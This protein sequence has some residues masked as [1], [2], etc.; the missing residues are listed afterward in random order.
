[1][2]TED[3]ISQYMDSPRELGLL[4]TE[5]ELRLWLLQNEPTPDQLEFASRF[6][7]MLV[8]K[9]AEVRE[10][11]FLNVSRLPKAQASTFEAFRTDDLSPAAAGQIESLKSL[12][13]ISAKRNIIMIGPTGTGKTHLAMAIGYSCIKNGISP[14]FIKMSELKAK[15]KRA[16]E[17]DSVGKMMLTLNKY[18]CLIIDEVGY[19]RFSKEETLLFFQLVDRFSLKD[20]SSIVLTSN[21]DIPFWKD[22]FSEYDALECTLDRLCNNSICIRFSGQSKR[23]GATSMIDIN[24]N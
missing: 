17:S 23:V 2:I 20:K 5:S 14:L 8:Q 7:R 13:F 24:Y 3:F 18:T 4:A 6:I 1:M 19:C 16:I 12:S 21:K 15:F 9:K 11:I 22:L 10:R